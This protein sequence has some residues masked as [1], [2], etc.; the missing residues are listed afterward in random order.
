MGR[1]IDARG[2][3]AIDVL[4]ALLG[5]VSEIAADPDISGMMKTGGSGGTVMDVARLM[6]KKHKSAVIEIMAIDDGKTAEEESKILSALTIPVR[7]IRILN[8][9]SVGE[10]LFGSAETGTPATGSASASGSGNG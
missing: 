7:L 5:P 6:L 10:L 8:T 9:P 3:E 1:I 4:E 2:E